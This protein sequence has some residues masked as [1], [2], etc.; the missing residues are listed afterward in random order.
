MKR[1]YYHGTAP[2]TLARILSAGMMKAPVYVAADLSLA[3][4]FSKHR[5]RFHPDKDARKERA[6]IKLDLTGFR[7][8]P[9]PDPEAQG[10]R[11]KGKLFIVDR[12]ITTKRIISVIRR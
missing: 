11:Y 2:I 3:L 5:M 7:L 8:R 6:V 4:T 12:N 10:K 9:D 1:Y